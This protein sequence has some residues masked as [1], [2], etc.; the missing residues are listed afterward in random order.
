MFKQ[1]R[2]G[3]PI[4]RVERESAL[5]NVDAAL[6]ELTGRKPAEALK[7]A[8]D[9]AVGRERIVLKER[10]AIAGGRQDRLSPRRHACDELEEEHA[11]REDVGTAEVDRA[12]HGRQPTPL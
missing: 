7:V 4:R 10:A 2:G 9:V 1:L 12:L 3:E 5:Q 6:A 8:E 11:E